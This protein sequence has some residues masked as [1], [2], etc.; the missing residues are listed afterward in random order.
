MDRVAQLQDEMRAGLTD[1]AAMKPPMPLGDRWMRHDVDPFD[2]SSAVLVGE[3]PDRI[4]RVLLRTADLPG[5]KPAIEWAIPSPTGAHIAV[6]IS[7]D[8]SEDATARVID[9]ETSQLLPDAVPHLFLSPVTWLADGSGFYTRCGE[10]SVKDG[11]NPRTVLHRLGGE[12]VVDETIDGPYKAVF[13]APT[14]ELLVMEGFGTSMTPILVKR[15]EGDAWQPLLDSTAGN[16]FGGVDS[17]RLLCGTNVNADRG[18]VVSI[19]L[20]TAAH[21]ST[22]T[23][24]IPEGDGVIRGVTQL[25]NHL[26]TYEIVD[27]AH[28]IRVFAADGTFDHTVALPEASGLDLNFGFGQGNGEPRVFADGPTSVVFHLGGFDRPARLVRYDILSREMTPLHP[29]SRDE[30][31]VATRH[32]A[33][34]PDGQE[35][36]YWHVRLRETRGPAPTI[37]YGYGGFNIAMHTPCYPAQVM[38]WLERG[39]CLVLPQ[40]RGGGEQGYS[41]WQAAVGTG[42]QRTFD[43]LFAVVEDAISEGLAARGRIG[44]VGAS[45][46][47]LTAGAAITQRPELFRAVI[48]AIPVLDLITL[49]HLG[50]GRFVKEYGIL[51]FPDHFAEWRRLSPL[52]NLRDG[53]HYPAVLIDAGEADVRCAIEPAR[54]F[55]ERLREIAGPDSHRVV[56]IERPH[57]GHVVAEGEVWPAWLDFFITELMESEA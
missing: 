22:W 21:T 53:V 11:W 16:F 19:P 4:D 40:L 15:A 49:P 24:L 14:G 36:G 18:R 55:A 35:V 23:E 26:V 31:L 13:G 25:D 32:R 29:V 46:G 37:V 38:P 6:G 47:G 17:D 34:A 2:G 41:H 3:T 48:C 20:D 5:P 12:T 28:R 52:Q 30:R 27:G 7:V 56:L 39:G 44:F 57:A 1:V 42:K 33:V 51:E 45:N 10:T 54:A 50:L 9:V 43:D 8:G